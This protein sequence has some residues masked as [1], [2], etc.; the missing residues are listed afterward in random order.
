[1]AM[2]DACRRQ[3][4]ALESMVSTL[5]GQTERMPNV[6]PEKYVRYV[7]FFFASNKS[8]SSGAGTKTAMEA[9]GRIEASGGAKDTELRSEPQHRGGRKRRI[10]RTTARRNTTSG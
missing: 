3:Q 9:Q 6:I 8:N 1:M 7:E 4:S 10:M 2:E 5:D